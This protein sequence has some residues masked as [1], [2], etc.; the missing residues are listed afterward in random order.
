M[1]KFQPLSKEIE[2]QLHGNRN[3]G[4]REESEANSEDSNF[5][6]SKLSAS[7]CHKLPAIVRNLK[8]SLIRQTGESDDSLR[9]CWM[10]RMDPL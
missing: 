3:S 1:R 4:S 7:M 10:Q 9:E 2:R 5:E 6:A 8:R